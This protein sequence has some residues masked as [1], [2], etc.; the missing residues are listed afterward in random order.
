MKE[1]NGQYIYTHSHII[2][3]YLTLKCLI[4]LTIK[5]LTYKW[6]EALRFQRTFKK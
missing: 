3:N 5:V 4:L 2:Q 1:T 6:H